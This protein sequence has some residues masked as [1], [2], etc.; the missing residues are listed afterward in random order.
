MKNTKP[1]RAEHLRRHRQI[2]EY[3]LAHG[4][5]LIEAEKA[6]VREEWQAA[7]DRLAAVQLC[8]RS[9][10]SREIAGG[11]PREFRTTIP[12][13]APWMMRD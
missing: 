3:A 4:L 6:L 10:A 5:T 8:G 1:T 12:A 9:V 7:Q 2:F 11:A 13:D